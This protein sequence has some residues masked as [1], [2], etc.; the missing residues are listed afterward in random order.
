VIGFPC[1]KP[2]GRNY[3]CDYRGNYAHDH[4]RVVAVGIR[5]H[6]WRIGWLNGWR[7]VDDAP[8]HAN[9]VLTFR[10]NVSV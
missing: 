2:D 9:N 10:E 8:F 5:G 3:R 1:E 7:I 4:P 6:V